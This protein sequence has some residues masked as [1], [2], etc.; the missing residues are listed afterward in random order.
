MLRG[1]PPLITA[2]LEQFTIER[3]AIT[4]YHDA[5]LDALASESKLPPVDD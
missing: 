2:V 1:Q 4:R 3:L 5:Y